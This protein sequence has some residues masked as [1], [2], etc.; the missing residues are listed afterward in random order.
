[1]NTLEITFLNATFTF[2]LHVT[3][4]SSL[5]QLALW[6]LLNLSSLP[7]VYLSTI[8]IL[9]LQ[10]EKQIMTVCDFLNIKNKKTKLQSFPGLLLPTNLRK[11]AE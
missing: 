7:G 10:K 2:L 5:V 4:Y 3:P 8:I 11:T 6:I 9:G 1:V